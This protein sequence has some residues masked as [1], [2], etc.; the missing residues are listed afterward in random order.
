M[1]SS[2]EVVQFRRLQNDVVTLAHRDLLN[3]WRTLDHTDG[4]AVRGALEVVFPELV[5]AYG[6]STATLAAD[7]FDDL[8]EASVAGGRFSAVLGDVAGTEQAQ[9]KMRWAIGP[10][11]ERS[12]PAQAFANLE[13][14]LDEYVKQP[15]RDTILQSVDRDPADARWARVPSGRGTCRWCRML[16]SRGAVYLTERTADG[17]RYHGHC[18]CV[19]TPIWDD[20]D[21]PE[22]YDPD[23][24]LDEYAAS[25]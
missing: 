18:D 25:L 20:T 12:D 24:L 7:R 1:A 17:G 3:F 6:L 19:P 2:A 16:A 13:L 10:L 11:F 23:A 4:V 14:S 22:G 9:A 15:A 8:R 21:L 5:Q